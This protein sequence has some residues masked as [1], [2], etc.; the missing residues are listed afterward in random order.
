MSTADPRCTHLT[1][2]RPG[3]PVASLPCGAKARYVTEAGE[4]IC[5]R[6]RTSLAQRPARV[7]ASDKKHAERMAKMRGEPIEDNSVAARLMRSQLGELHATI[8]GLRDEVDELRSAR[9]R[10]QEATKRAEDAEAEAANLREMAVNIVRDMGALMVRCHG[11]NEDNDI[12]QS[13][14]ARATSF[15]NGHEGKS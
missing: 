14:L 15:I 4:P 1:L 5:G 11:C 12:I 6:H 2:I 3:D 7:A 9:H 13:V 10:E 8:S